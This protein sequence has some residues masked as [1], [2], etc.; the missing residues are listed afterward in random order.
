MRRQSKADNLSVKQAAVLTALEGLWRLELDWNRRYRRLVAYL[1][2]GGTTE[3]PANRTG[4]G[5][6]PAFRPGTGLRKQYWARTGGKP[7]EWQ[8]VLLDALHG[9]VGVTVTG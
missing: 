7:T 2:A 4:L 6:D 3:G 9:H 8:T 5:D 1:A